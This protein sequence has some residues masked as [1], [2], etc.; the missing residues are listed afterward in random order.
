[1]RYLQRASR[2]AYESERS[3]SL[4][5]LDESTAGRFRSCIECRL[6][7]VFRRDGGFAELDAEKSPTSVAGACTSPLAAL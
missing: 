5:R 2:R 1:M 4:K 7:S 6:P 3:R